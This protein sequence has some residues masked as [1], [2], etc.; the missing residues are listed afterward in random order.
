MKH[1]KQCPEC[2]GTEI[3][4]RNVSAQASDSQGPDLLPYLGGA[5]NRP[6]FD[7]FICGHC[8]CCRWFVGENW[9]EDVK[10]HYE[11]CS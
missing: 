1:T 6:Q 5:F 11:R 10:A 7:I 3:F 8:G 9:L 4:T 2:G